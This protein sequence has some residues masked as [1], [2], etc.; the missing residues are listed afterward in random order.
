MARRRLVLAVSLAVL[1]ATG[2]GCSAGSSPPP[3]AARAS[4]KD[5]PSIPTTTSVP[6]TTTTLPP[7]PSTTV[8]LPPAQ[9]PGWTKALT[10]LPPGGGF[11]SLSC[12]SD[13][14][15]IAAGGGTG[16][17]VAP[18]I[19]GSGV[20]VSWDGA[21]WSD[22][23]VYLPAPA[24]GT[25]TAPVLPSIDCTSG[26]TCVIV[27]G[28]GH[29][30]EGDGTDWYGVSALSPGPPLPADPADPGPD[31]LDSRDDA[32]SC[33]SPKFCAVV[34]NTGH[35]YTWSDGSWLAT[36]SLGLPTGAG[37]SGPVSSLYQAGRVGIS[38]PSRTFCEAV[39]GTSV[40]DWNGTTWS[41]EPTPWTPSLPA[42]SDATAISCA[43]TSL[44]AIVS[45]T[46]LSYRN[47]SETWSPLEDI[48]PHGGLDAISCPTTTFCLAADSGGSVTAWNGS[49][50][51]VPQQVIPEATQYPGI[52]TALS[53]PSPDSCMLINADGDFATY[54][55]D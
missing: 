9:V 6:T 17:Q 38:C 55:S 45:G 33:P 46:D 32:V 52:G 37:G 5:T 21:A 23:S 24:T 48:D 12:I 30:S 22:P 10:T 51:S 16:G 2:Y 18:E 15:C 36:R 54:S 26:P 19:T 3:G 14:F 34:D 1:A 13:T 27:D 28:S 47:G 40:L 31:H 25:V 4:A 20:T 8:P 11:S 29:V 53:C 50:W 49:S 35:A 39:V 41:V 44:C 43:T 7:V 42:G